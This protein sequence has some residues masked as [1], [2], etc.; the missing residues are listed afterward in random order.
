[1]DVAT[2]RI[3]SNT[4]QIVMTEASIPGHNLETNVRD[5]IRYCGRH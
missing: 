1:M 2:V 4:S 3:V 5:E